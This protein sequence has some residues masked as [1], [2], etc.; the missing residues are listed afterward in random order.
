MTPGEKEFPPH[1]LAY[2]SIGSNID[3]EKNLRAAVDLLS[4]FGKVL[5][6]S[7]V[8]ETAP[9]GRPGQPV[10]LNAAVLLETPLS[11]MDL[12][13]EAIA[14]VESEL[15]RVRT[16]DKYAPRTIDVDIMLFNRDVMDIGHRHIP[17]EEIMERPFVAITLAEIAP[18]YVHPETGQTL[19]QIA[20][21]FDPEQAGMQRRDDLCL[22]F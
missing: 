5:R 12:H 22:D 4:R 20:K 1:N 3:P 11:A 18:R 13:S 9:I 7:T 10:Y 2:L 15:G 17:D 19:E 8:W 21:G 14:A 6:T 16:G